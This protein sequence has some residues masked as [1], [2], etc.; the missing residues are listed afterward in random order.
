MSELLPGL[1]SEKRS[2][3]PIDLHCGR[4]QSV[5]ADVE[6]DTLMA[7]PPYSDRTHAGQRTGS[8]IRVSTIE[9]AALT[10]D[11]AHELA[12]AWHER[13]RW[14][15]VLFCDHKAFAWH[16]EAWLERGWLVFSPVFLKNNPPPRFSGDGP[17]LALE[18]LCC[19]RRRTSERKSGSLPGYYVFDCG[20]DRRSES[21]ILAGRKP[22]GLMRA[23]VR[24]YSRPGDL[25][26]DPCAGGATTLLA[27]AIEGRRA[28]GAEMD[29]NTFALAQKRIARGFTPT[30]DF[31]ANP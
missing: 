7:D 5:L 18:F 21:A 24:D 19:A 3:E 20:H 4:W 25:I 29:P 13:T 31:E 8:S 28:V 1:E 17:T 15:A 11:D 6:C 10:R 2:R 16:E 22:L 26:C 14:W 23:L 12:R 30:F 9:Y 27:A